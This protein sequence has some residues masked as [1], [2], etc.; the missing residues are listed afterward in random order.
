M[1]AMEEPPAVVREVP[2]EKADRNGTITVTAP[3]V[4][5]PKAKAREFLQ[6]VLPVPTMG[7]YASW[8][9]PVCVKVYGLDAE[10]EKRVRNRVEAVATAAGAKVAEE[11]CR[12]N[13]GIV[14]TDNG[15]QQ[16]IELRKKRGRL[17]AHLPME[18]IRALRQGRHPVVWWRIASGGGGTGGPDAG[19]AA[20]VSAP[21]AGEMPLMNMFGGEVPST[22]RYDGGSLI[23]TGLSLSVG[24]AIAIVDVEKAEGKSLDAVA[25]YVAFVTIGPVRFPADPTGVPSILNL[26]SQDSEALELSGWDRSLLSANTRMQLDRTARWQAGKMRAHM[27]RDQRESAQAAE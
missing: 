9:R 3:Q 24:A 6:Q 10:L 21:G 12:P 14:F 8:T 18:E 25:D 26:F 20:I 2:Q 16:I 11:S 23:S 1:F 15:Q 19:T 22:A 13:I 27:V 17:L 5:P 7:Q 4:E